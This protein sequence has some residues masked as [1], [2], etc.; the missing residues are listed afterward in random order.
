MAQL[1]QEL[2]AFVDGAHDSCVVIQVQNSVA[3]EDDY[4]PEGDLLA[5]L[6]RR[7]RLLEAAV[8]AARRMCSG[9]AL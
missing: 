5:A 3:S 1:L 6:A 2:S 9:S 8:A 7:I 4:L